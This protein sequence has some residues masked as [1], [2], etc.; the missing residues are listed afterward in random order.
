M[1]ETRNN[2]RN[3]ARNNARN[4]ARNKA[5]NNA[6]KTNLFCTGSGLYKNILKPLFSIFSVLTKHMLH[7]L[8]LFLQTYVYW[9]GKNI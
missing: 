6:L 4:K 5:R 8:M 3:N 1:Q 7:L 2:V 9:G